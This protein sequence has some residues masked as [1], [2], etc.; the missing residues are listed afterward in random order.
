MQAQGPG[1]Y[2]FYGCYLHL[3]STG[4]TR[5]LKLKALVFHSIKERKLKSD[6]LVNY[7][8][9]TFIAQALFKGGVTLFQ[10]TLYLNAIFSIFSLMFFQRIAFKL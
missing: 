7:P 10:T 8:S 6:K 3:H 1:Y 9:K 2:S 4:Q 5:R